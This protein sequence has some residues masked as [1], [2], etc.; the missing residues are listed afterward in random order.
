MNN[1]AQNSVILARGHTDA[2][3]KRIIVVVAVAADACWR[4]RVGWIDAVPGRSI[5]ADVVRQSTTRVTDSVWM[6]SPLDDKLVSK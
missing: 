6:S 3:G 4:G 2:S 1:G 5:T